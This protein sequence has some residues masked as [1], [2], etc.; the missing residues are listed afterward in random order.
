MWKPTPDIQHDVLKNSNKH[1]NKYDK[2]DN[3]KVA[4]VDSKFVKDV[5]KNV[6][7]P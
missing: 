2:N 5:N 7:G 3:K 4:M 1:K 6:F